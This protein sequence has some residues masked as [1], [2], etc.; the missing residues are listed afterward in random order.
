[1][2]EVMAF[3]RP[4]KINATKTALAN[5]GFPAFTCRPCLGRGKQMGLSY[6]L[7]GTLSEGDLPT[8]Q[9]GESLSE[10]TRLVAK[11][12]FT[13]IVKDDEVKKVVDIIIDANQTGNPG[14]GKVFVLP[15]YEAI[16]IRTGETTM[17]AF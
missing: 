10:R 15:I 13:L 16:T 12:F 9:I 17:D 5:N 7:L 8:N 14:D 11:R 2:K 3:L 1:M 6:E 4:N